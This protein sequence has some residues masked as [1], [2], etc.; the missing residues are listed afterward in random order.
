VRGQPRITV[1]ERRATASTQEKNM[2]TTLSRTYSPT[3]AVPLSI[4]I[5]AVFAGAVNALL[6]LVG[7][8][9]GA[10]GPGLQPIAYLSLTIIAAIAG[11]IGRIE[12]ASRY[13]GEASITRRHGGF[14]QT[15][16]RPCRVSPD[17]SAASI[18][19]LSTRLR[20]R[21]ADPA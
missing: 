9:M 3:A 19:P 16:T 10:D 14:E 12:S 17:S 6:A 2:S 21:R 13:S 11:A 1:A 18:R 7:S 4:A 20:R 8:S 5:V 15:S